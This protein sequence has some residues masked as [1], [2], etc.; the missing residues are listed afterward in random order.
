M[1]G[2][3]YRQFDDKVMMFV[4]SSYK[5]S[6]LLLYTPE[7]MIISKKTLERYRDKIKI[8]ESKCKVIE[9]E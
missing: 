6:P 3:I 4:D 1:A 8:D 5:G 2:I 9:I 7:I